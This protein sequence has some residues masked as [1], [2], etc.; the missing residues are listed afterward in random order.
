L[1]SG[2]KN[3][4]A[5]F[6]DLSQA[7]DSIT[8]AKLWQKFRAGLSTKFI[9]TNRHIYKKAKSVI[10]TNKGFSSSVPMERAV[11]QGETLSPK[12]FTIFMDD[13]VDMLHNSNL[14]ALQ[15]GAAAIHL[16]V[17][18]DEIICFQLPQS[19]CKRK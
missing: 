14:P 2:Y 16:L 8:H 10:R 11:L 19:T 12:L 1:D 4:Y 18:A 6:V 13:I 17:Y 7:F 3:V 9:N 15:V 5:L